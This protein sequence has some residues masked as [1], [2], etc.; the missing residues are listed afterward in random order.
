M[1]RTGKQQGSVSRL[2]LSVADPDSGAAAGA[3]ALI[4]DR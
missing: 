1:V 3:E 2:G 4:R